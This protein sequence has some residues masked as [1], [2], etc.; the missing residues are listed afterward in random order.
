MTYSYQD[1]EFPNH[2]TANQFFNRRLFE[3]YHILGRH[4]GKELL[5]LVDNLKKGPE[6]VPLEPSNSNDFTGKQEL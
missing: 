2:S 5:K 3:S 1:A 4:S 6:P